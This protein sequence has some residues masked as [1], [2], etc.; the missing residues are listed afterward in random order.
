VWENVRIFRCGGMLVSK[1]GFDMEVFVLQAE[2]S[3][4]LAHPL[5]LAILHCLKDGEKTVNE[6]TEAVGASQSNVSQHLALMRQRGIVKTRKAGAAVYYRLA[7]PKI[8][9]AC[10][11]VREVLMEQLSQRQEMA[12]S[13]SQ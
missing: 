1:S 8:G 10:D 13:F 5:R 2:I 12:R 6:L 11:M 4:T 3:K 9:L 7:S